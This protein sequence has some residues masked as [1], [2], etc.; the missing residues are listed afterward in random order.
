M[1]SAELNQDSVT[2]DII[3]MYLINIEGT[4]QGK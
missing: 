1:D 3:K 2:N 4:S